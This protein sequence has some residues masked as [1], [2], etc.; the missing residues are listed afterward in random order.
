[1]AV[2]VLVVD[3]ASFARQLVRTAL[4]PLES[5][6]VLEARDARTALG[7]LERGDIDLIVA[8][9]NMPGMDGLQMLHALRERSAR[10]LP[11]LML[12]AVA[13]GPLLKRGAQLGVSAWLE[14]PVQVSVLR[15]AV[16]RLLGLP[17]ERPSRS[18]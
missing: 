1:M 12:T 9:L 14:K 10:E 13:P 4:S 3:D 8:D 17:I 7:L 6:Q 5:V 16:A 11:V 15:A 2:Q 18:A